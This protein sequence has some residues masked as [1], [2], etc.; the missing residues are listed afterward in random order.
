MPPQPISS[1]TLAFIVFTASS[2]LAA[3]SNNGGQPIDLNRAFAMSKFDVCKGTRILTKMEVMKMRAFSSKVFAK[4]GSSMLMH[5][6]KKFNV[7][8]FLLHHICN[9]MCTGLVITYGALSKR[10]DLT[11]PPTVKQEQIIRY[12][13]RLNTARSRGRN[14]SVFRDP[15][16]PTTEYKWS[17]NALGEFVAQMARCAY[18]A[19]NNV[20]VLD[21][22]VVLRLISYYKSV[23]S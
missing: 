9:V 16:D 22:N 20:P 13:D 14:V 1:F 7:P 12:Y 8:A 3:S 5:Y 10:G 18:E 11:I 21:G 19:N 23:L 6:S 17:T 2:T 15:K 4:C